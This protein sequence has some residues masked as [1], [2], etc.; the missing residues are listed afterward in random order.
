[1]TKKY[2]FTIDDSKLI[3]LEDAIFDSKMDDYVWWEDKNT[4]V[5]TDNPK[6]VNDLDVIFEDLGIEYTSEEF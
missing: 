4:C 3:E 6:V 1:M 2:R 5:A